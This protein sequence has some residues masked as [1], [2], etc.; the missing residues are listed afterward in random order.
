MKDM[1]NVQSTKLQ[2]SHLL[3]IVKEDGNP[4]EEEEVDI[5]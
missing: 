5:I 4:E 2:N 1:P 3:K